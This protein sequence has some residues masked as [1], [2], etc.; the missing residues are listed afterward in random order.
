MGHGGG[1]RGAGSRGRHPT[2]FDGEPL[3]YGK[4]GFRNPGFVAWGRM[5][6]LRRARA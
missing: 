4:P 3:L 6:L 1:A 2:T 5:P